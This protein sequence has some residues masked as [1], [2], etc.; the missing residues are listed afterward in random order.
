MALRVRYRCAD[1]DVEV[2]GPGQTILDISI[3]SKIPHWRECGGRGKCSTCR[4]RVL[5]GAANLSP[6]NAVERQLARAR[7]WAPAIR[8]ACQAVLG[9]VALERVLLSGADAS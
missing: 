2:G 3:G 4:V 5:D 1:R 6:A 7:R 9:D 8:L